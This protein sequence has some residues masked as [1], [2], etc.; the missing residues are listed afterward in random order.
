M[1]QNKIQYEFNGEQDGWH[2]FYSIWTHQVRQGQDIA[3]YLCEDRQ[4]G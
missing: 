4:D 2:S 3:S 1:P